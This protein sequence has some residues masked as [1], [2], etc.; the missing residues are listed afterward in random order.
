[1]SD[2]G[3]DLWRTTMR[4]IEQFLYAEVALLDDQDYPSWLKLFTPDA[5]YWIPSGAAQTDPTKDVS[6][7]YD[8]MD[9]LAERV[10]RMDSGLAYCQQ[11]SSRTAH[12]V[13]NIRLDDQRDSEYY[14]TAGFIVAEY[15]RHTQTHH[16]GRYRY[17]LRKDGGELQIA[18][19]KVELISNN[20]HLGNL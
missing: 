15:R 17:Q 10:W 13:T 5:R 18:L 1:I 3:L 2:A 9:F 19:K 20:G 6:I 8:D 16:A 11:P 4:E 14:V 12:L 7:V